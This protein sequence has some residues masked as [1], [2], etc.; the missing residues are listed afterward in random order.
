MTS[1][2]WIGGRVR[3]IDQT[4]LPAD[5][6]YVETSDY[7][8][9]GEAIKKLQIRG[10]PAIGVA[11][12]FAVVLA[13]NNS[14]N[15]D[16]EEL[17]NEFHTA[18]KYLSQTRPTAVNLFAA[19]HRMERAFERV[20]ADGVVAARSRLL[21]EAKA[22]E[23]ED[24]DACR[25]I[26]EYGATLIEPGSSILTH[27]NT[28]A[29]ATAGAGTALSII[30]TAAK[31]NKIVRV[32][33]DETR[34]LLQ[35][36]RL[37]TWELM[38]Q[39][40]DCILVTDST[41]GFLMQQRQVNAIIVGAD[42][43]AA[44]G[45][46]ANKIGTFPLAVLAEKHTIPFYVAAPTSTIDIGTPTGKEIPIEERDANEVTHIA[47]VQIAPDGVKVFAPAF[48][49]TPNELITA[50]ITE[51]GILKPPYQESI[52]EVKNLRVQASEHTS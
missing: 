49:V 6:V 13:V 28:G 25:K 37:T 27:C 48:D 5:E 12:A 39:G 46:V 11:A 16:P 44:N 41:A 8:V 1:V 50:I 29:L 26:G 24:V 42:R 22:I 19:L 47:G 35:G 21:Q 34:P 17:R 4:R 20:S 14:G 43:I 38:K 9:V 3:F 33:V 30:A 15:T 32:F 45:D 31:Q 10:A 51:T 7:H 36:A 40:I 23:K 52:G 18:I 2:E